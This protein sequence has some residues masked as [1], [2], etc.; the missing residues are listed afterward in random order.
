MKKQKFNV[1]GMTCSACSARVESTTAKLKGV[2]SA[3]VNLLANSML[4]VYDETLL[5]AE[6]ICHAVINVGYGASVAEKTASRQ[7]AQA[8]GHLKA[9][10]KR[11]LTSFLLLL[12]LMYVAMGHMLL[13]PVPAFLHDPA[14]LAITELLL[15]APILAVN[16]G[17]FSRGFKNLFHGAPNMDSMV[18]VG[19]T[20]A[21][22]YSVY[23]AIS[24]VVGGGEISHHLYFES[25]AMILTLVTLGKYMEARSKGETGRAIEKLMD[26]EPK[27]ACVL[28]DGE[29]K[30][31]PVAEVVVGDT[32]L[33][34]P[35]QSIPVDG[36]VLEGSSTVDE[37]MLTGESI[38]VEKTVGDH[39]GAATV[40][41]TGSLTFRAERVGQD[42]T[43]AGIIRLVE[44]ASASKAPIFRL[45]DKIAG[46]FVPVVMS[47]AVITVIVWLLA[48]ATFEFALTSGIAV[49][50]ISCPC[51][52]G[53]AT[54]VSVMVGTGRGAE[55]GI[56]LKSAEVLETMCH[57]DTVVLDKT[58]TLTQGH[59]AVTD[60]LP[61]NGNVMDFLRIAAALEQNSEHPLAVAV[62]DAAK[63]LTIPSVTDF[64]AVPGK[65]VM[66]V[67]DG[68]TYLGGN[69]QFLQENG[70]GVEERHD[71]TTQGKTLLYFGEQNGA[72]LGV[73]AAADKE[74]PT[75]AQAV[76]T[77]QQKGLKVIMLTGDNADTARAV[78]ER[79]G[80]DQV[81]AQVL[82]QDKEQNVRQ[83]QEKGHKVIMVGDGINDAPALTAADVGMAIGAGTDIAM[84]SADA[85]LMRSDPMD[86]VGGIELSH[87]VMKKIRL[88]LFW[89]F[90]YN[91]L[92]IPIAA[93]VLYP[94][95]GLQLNPMLG[96]AAMS[97]SSVCVVSN[98]LRLRTWKPTAAKETCHDHCHDHC[99]FETHKEEKIMQ[100][101]LNITGMMC[102]HCQ[103]HVEKALLAVS[104]VE[105]VEVDLQGGKATVQ[106]GE[107]AELLAAVREVGYGAE[108]A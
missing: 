8:D 71:L 96:A 78:G 55:Y 32:V 81:I 57:A 76:K 85:V 19:S 51:A 93:G 17:Y 82:P 67:L 43:L 5:T 60:I 16:F 84:E 53:L 2:K 18:A 47:I 20:A 50:V 62:L 7:T 104:G 54:P 75:A 105:K 12:P 48:G 64:S 29:E 59:P 38:P 88:N 37:S 49:L 89:A 86:I 97:I 46:L 83:L 66:G 100:Y 13:L 74:K 44:E 36:V 11:L 41:L 3:S 35:G 63:D 31:I 107:I 95:F 72:Y 23:A 91:F 87:A 4:V 45:A 1:T 77:L 56:L 92:C 26:L 15:T 40:N 9:M 25:A 42:T 33:I 98:S 58:G 61:Q 65:G 69:A 70:I 94:I 73:I 21:F 101:T 52:L 99:E 27:T 10:K 6:D 34:R 106:G 90:F 28:R 108:E 24:A 30:I 80:V 39:L 22:A 103:A 68:K 102:P 14:L 79:L